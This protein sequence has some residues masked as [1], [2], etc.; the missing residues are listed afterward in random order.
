[1]PRLWRL[2]ALK[3]DRSANRSSRTLPVASGIVG[4]P[5]AVPG[6]PTLRLGLYRVAEA[7]EHRV[8]VF[9]DHPAT[10]SYAH[11]VVRKRTFGI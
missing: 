4:E 5:E 11:F 6:T 7:R 3:L 10:G 8:S 2:S 1:M 9:P